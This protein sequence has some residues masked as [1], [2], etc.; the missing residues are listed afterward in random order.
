MMACVRI[1]NK[2]AFHVPKNANRGVARSRSR[3]LVLRRDELRCLKPAAAKCGRF[4]TNTRVYYDISDFVKLA[5][6]CLFNL[7]SSS[8]GAFYQYPAPQC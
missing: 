6:F 3:R 2:N 5:P 1:V 7:I 4:I 8:D